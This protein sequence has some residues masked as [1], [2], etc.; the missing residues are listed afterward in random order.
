MK[1]ATVNE[2]HPNHDIP[3]G[4]LLRIIPNW[5]VERET[6]LV[7]CV[8]ARQDVEIARLAVYIFNPKDLTEISEEVADIMMSVL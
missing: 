7:R 8:Y 5:R 1:Y 4:T 3:E 6:E 2:Y